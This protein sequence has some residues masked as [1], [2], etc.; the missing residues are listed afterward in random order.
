MFSHDKAFELINQ[1]NKQIKKL[2]ELCLDAGEK[3]KA[4]FLE[5]K[6][7][8]NIFVTNNSK[9]HMLHPFGAATPKLKL[10]IVSTFKFF[11]VFLAIR[12]K[13]NSS[14]NEP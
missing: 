1:N 3:K 5:Q 6:K 11:R 14:N 4:E 8:L 2:L 7:K 9:L 10:N 12:N 13:N